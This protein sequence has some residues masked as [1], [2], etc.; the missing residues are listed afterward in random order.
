MMHQWHMMHRFILSLM[1]PF[2]VAGAPLLVIDHRAARL[3]PPSP[4]EHE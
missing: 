1:T 3:S 2:D 4:I